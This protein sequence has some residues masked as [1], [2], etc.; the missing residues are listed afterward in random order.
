MINIFLNHLVAFK[1][2]IFDST[3]SNKLVNPPYVAI[4]RKEENKIIN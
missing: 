1:V 3:C 2:L 4:R